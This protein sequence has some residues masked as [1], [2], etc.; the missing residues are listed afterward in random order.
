MNPLEQSEP[1]TLSLANPN[2]RSS[3]TK[4]GPVYRI[5]F[6][7]EQDDYLNFMN[8][9]TNG[10]V[11]DAALQVVENVPVEPKKPKAAKGQY[12]EYAKKLKLSS[13]FRSP[14]VWAAL[15]TDEEFREWIQQQPSCISGDRDYCETLTGDAEMV[16]KAA[17]VRR[18]GESGTGYKAEYACVPL[19][20]E[21]HSCQHQHGELSCLEI[22]L[23]SFPK[24]E[25]NV[26][27]ADCI[28]KEWFDKKRIDY[29]S[30]WAWETYKG[31]LGV[32]SMAEVSPEIHKENAQ[33]IEAEIVALLPHCGSS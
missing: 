2:P 17:H 26:S 22:H 33:S 14:K 10:M 31:K 20:N 16:C 21:E 6:E 27:A 3:K 18:A 28:A 11:L 8:T 19:T 4:D 24:N 1:Y 32:S 13:F 23:K 12:G 30:K 9:Q 5:S 25:S 7:I 29:V 15:G